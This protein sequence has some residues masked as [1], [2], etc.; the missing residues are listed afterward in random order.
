MTPS[1]AFAAESK[2]YALMECRSTTA[3]EFTGYANTY[4]RDVYGDRI[5]PGA[6]GPTIR[7]QRGKIPLFMDHV[8]D[9][10]IGFSSDLAED[11]K[12][13]YIQGV[14]ALDTSRGKDA[15]AL[16]KAAE[17]ADF[18]MGLSIGFVPVEVETDQKDGSRIIKQLDL[19]ET[20]LTAF[21]ANRQSRVD[22]VKSVR[23]IEHLLRDVGGCSR[24]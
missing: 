8:R 23:D 24:E 22:S 18:R 20:S 7:E 21:P 1:A 11:A 9:W 3:G 4:N 6:F 19:R 5:A 10:P 17:A 13:L 14:L 15:Y 16:L 2:T 12:G